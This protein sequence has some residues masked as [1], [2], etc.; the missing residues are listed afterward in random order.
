MDLNDHAQF[1]E[2]D[3]QGMLDHINGLP[4]QL[5]VAYE[6][7][8]NL[9]LPLIVPIKSIVAAGMGGSAI[10]ADLIAA[11]VS[12]H[13]QVPFIVHRDYGLPAFAA[14]SEMLVIL[15]SHSGNTEE[16]LS[17][18]F[19]ALERGCQV[20]VITT[21][22][23]LELEGVKAGVPI[24][25]FS[26]TG[27]PRTAVGFSFGLILA[28]ITRLGLINSVESELEEALVV[29]EELKNRIKADVP[30]MLNSAK[31]QA[32]QFIGRH[33]SIY[34]GGFLAPVARR[35]KTQLNEVAKSFAAFEILPEADHNTL[36]GIYNP[37]Q[38]VSQEYAMFLASSLDHPRNQLRLKKTR[39][40]FML[41]G[42]ATDTLNAKG[43][44]RLAQIWSA[45]LFGDYVAYYMALLYNIDPT[46]IPPIA[47]LKE[48]MT[49]N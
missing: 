4:A 10:G 42:I 46:P 43:K 16:T 14:G 8:M 6:M 37:G 33:V 20:I 45:L 21:G 32:G 30:V 15:S 12:D 5:K 31:R 26:H 29:M 18:F 34:A 47:E 40:L 28:L 2:I 9:P 17:S 22:G 38:Q 36:A 39:E 1:S 3:T 27:Q 25:K 19:A 35:W 44:S 48:A 23:K 24:W 7:G 13:L 41:E 49:D 11:Y